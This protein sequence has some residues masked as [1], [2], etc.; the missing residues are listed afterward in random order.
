[1]ALVRPCPLF[2]SFDDLN[3]R[4]CKLIRS[5]N[6]HLNFEYVTKLMFKK[7]PHLKYLS[8][9]NLNIG[10]ETFQI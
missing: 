10:G 8:L 2:Y 7:L 3:K 5:T 1:M 6:L 4:F 9:T